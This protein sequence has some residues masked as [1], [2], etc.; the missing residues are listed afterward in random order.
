[1]RV[2]FW[3]RIPRSS[4]VTGEDTGWRS[5]FLRPDST[6][7]CHDRS[8]DRVN[9]QILR[10]D[11]TRTCHNR[12]WDLVTGA[13]SLHGATGGGVLV[14]VLARGGSV[15]AKVRHCVGVR[16]GARSLARWLTSWPRWYEIASPI[17]SANRLCRVIIRAILL[18]VGGILPGY[19]S[20]IRVGDL[21]GFLFFCCFGRFHLRH[22]LLPLQSLCVQISAS[23]HSSRF[24]AGSW[25][26]SWHW[27][28]QLWPGWTWRDL[29][30]SLPEHLWVINCVLFF[31]VV[32][33]SRTQWSLGMWLASIACL[34]SWFLLSFW[35]FFR[36]PGATVSGKQC[37]FQKWL[38]SSMVA[39]TLHA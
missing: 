28:W 9:Q 38:F 22:S 23:T 12:S 8:R 5:R 15:R 35:F 21:V 11:S 39:N 2:G 1:M 18:L 27:R 34:W 31:D 32:C 17:A 24:G 30:L 7:A 6:V 19:I 25:S 26:S 14:V 10:P 29:S 4:V 20:S 16:A 36:F 13:G 37:V 33:T 3:G